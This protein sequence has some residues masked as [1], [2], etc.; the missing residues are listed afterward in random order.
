MAACTTLGLLALSCDKQRKVNV[1]QLP[2]RDGDWR[3]RRVQTLG[4][5]SLSVAFG[6]SAE[7][8]EEHLDFYAV[9]FSL[10]FTGASPE[11]GGR[12]ELLV[13]D[14]AQQS[15]HVVDPVAGTHLGYVF[16][17]QKRWVPGSV[18]GRAALAAVSVTQMDGLKVVCL[19]EGRGAE[20][21]F[22]RVLGAASG[23]DVQPVRFMADGSGVAVG[24]DR[25]V[26]VYS[27]VDGGHIASA[28]MCR[29]PAAEVCLHDDVEH[30]DDFEV[31]ADD[32]L[33]VASGQT[34]RFIPGCGDVTWLRLP[35][36]LH[37]T[38]LCVVPG[39]GLVIKARCAMRSSVLL[40]G[41][42]DA[43]AQAGMSAAR[44]AWMGAVARGVFDR[45]RLRAAASVSVA[46][47]QRGRCQR[48]RT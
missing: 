36:R 30:V 28:F 25:G 3:M 10:A 37:P 23:C 40:Y 5:S 46:S 15:V 27:L 29:N 39:L 20:W 41:T 35:G 17:R 26:C 2:G 33:V 13:A 14:A 8:A 12:P 19:F 43:I 38:A 22:L 21:R 16:G 48:R 32:G 1:Y 11:G 7:E 47:A 31:A 34:V 9:V 18:A 45:V 24:Y 4:A 6:P 44:V 42:P